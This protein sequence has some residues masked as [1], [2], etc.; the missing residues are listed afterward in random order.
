M[1]YFPGE[2]YPTESDFTEHFKKYP[3]PLSDFQKYAIEGIEKG[4]HVLIGAHTGSGK[5]LPAEYA[6]EKFA[7][8][9][10]KIIYTTPIKALSNQKYNDFTEK[11]GQQ[12]SFGILTGDIKANSEADCLIMTTEI[13]R[14]TL[15]QKTMNQ[16]SDDKNLPLHFDMD[17]DNDL[18]CVIF[19]EVH[20][21]NDPDRGRIWEETIMMLPDS[22]LMVM[23]SAT[24]D[25][26]LSFAEWIE[27]NKTKGVYLTQTSERV[28]PLYHYSYITAPTSFIDKTH[29]KTYSTLFQENMNRLVPLKQKQGEFIETN[30]Y[31][32]IKIIKYLEKND[33]RISQKFV[34]N[35][36]VKFLK[37]KGM[38]PAI[39]FVL[40]RKMCYRY[41]S[42]ISENLFPEDSKAVSLV[43][44]ECLNT[45][46]RLP[47]HQEYIHLPEFTNI[48]K[49]MEKGVAVH[50]SGV[51]PI[52]KEM[53]E[54]M[55]AKGF[56]KLLFATETFAVG[57]N[58]PTKTVIFTG[59]KKFS[60]SGFRTL[61]SHEYTQMAGRAGRR[62]LDTVGYVI[63]LNSIMENPLAS[64]YKMMLSGKPQ[65]LTSKFSIEYNLLLNI[66]ATQPDK[67]AKISD[68][69]AFATRSMMND[70][71]QKELQETKKEYQE[72]EATKK[73]KLLQQTGFTTK[74]E[75]IES[76]LQKKH[77][78]TMVKPKQRKRIQREITE[79][80]SVN[81]KIADESE[82]VIQIRNITNT[83]GKVE[84]RIANINNYITNNI[85]TVVNILIEKGFINVV[86][87]TQILTLTTK[88]LIAANIQETHGLSFAEAI[89]SQQGNIFNQL[90]S[91]QIAGVFSCFTNLKVSDIL[92]DAVIKTTDNDLK[93]TVKYLEDSYRKY[94][95]LESKEKIYTGYDYD[96]SY[97]MVQPVM[98]WFDA[99]DELAAKQII[100]KVEKNKDIF[101]GEFIK[102]ILKIN[103]IATEFEKISELIGNLDLLQKC[104]EIH[105]RT[106]KFVATN[107][108]LYV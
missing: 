82:K 106:L 75:D 18:G 38:L 51:L 20:Y 48:V 52:F 22:V 32:I 24:M 61:H 89:V 103:N 68:L 107:Q 101:I 37:M 57:V 1:V 44:T 78:I 6:I 3:F 65:T 5:T 104:K 105:E 59:F 33:I 39:C 45:L 17:I 74:H 21:I 53:I 55:F 16:K 79:L 13:L 41:A 92:K 91:Q 30:F 64:E 71:I 100:D 36:V 4:H 56:V 80:E 60:G 9:G 25:R 97:D 40:S 23:L 83:M 81:K 14:N 58:M 27:R 19:D 66:I 47:N 12:H 98:D 7:S 42:E 28:V 99:S 67:T 87:E 54:M 85:K 15:F 70:E 94:S 86:E 93:Y 10:K 96:V 95:D 8:I 49:L 11:F 69:V 34:L 29:D 35:E 72:L 43:K 73:N 50:H 102:V 84:Q 77:M 90:T 26:P 88:G 2:S 108:S 31:K 46:R 63:H 76:Y 62:G